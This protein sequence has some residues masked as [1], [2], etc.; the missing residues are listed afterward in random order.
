M[1]VV[2]CD[3][4]MTLCVLN[5]YK[6]GWFVHVNLLSPCVRCVCLCVQCI[7]L[8]AV[9]EW[10]ACVQCAYDHVCLRVVCVPDV[11]MISQGMRYEV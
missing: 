2:S 1:E 3:S 10:C 9:C 4:H 8:C 11:S 6:C 5:V 7:C